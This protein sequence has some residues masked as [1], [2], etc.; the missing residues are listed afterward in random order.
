MSFSVDE[1]WAAHSSLPPSLYDMGGGPPT[2]ASAL[3]AAP[4]I[5]VEA[6]DDVAEQHNPS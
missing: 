3:D 6:V 1:R 4:G 5:C 2:T